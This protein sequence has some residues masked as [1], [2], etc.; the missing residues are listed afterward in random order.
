MG[1]SIKH[2][3]DFGLE[4]FVCWAYYVV[5]CAYY[6]FVQYT[7][8][9]EEVYWAYALKRTWALVEFG[10][11]GLDLQFFGSECILG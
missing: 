7:K 3:M 1:S 6:P 8:R 4:M 10:T 11:L 9:T 2:L 5:R